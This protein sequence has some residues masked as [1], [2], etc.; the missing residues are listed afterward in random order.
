MRIVH[1]SCLAE[2]YVSLCDETG[3]KQL[4]PGG[5]KDNACCGSKMAFS[6]SLFLSSAA[7]H[8]AIVMALR[9]AENCNNT[10]EC[11]AHFE[12]IA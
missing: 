10:H 5:S 8:R 9:S 2:H 7:V 12:I 6:R 11:I 4:S 3:I 1:A